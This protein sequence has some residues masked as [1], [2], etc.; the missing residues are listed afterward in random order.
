M[1]HS[2]HQRH[3]T[4][5]KLSRTRKDLK[6]RRVSNKHAASRT[7]SCQV[8]FELHGVAMCT[9][10]VRPH[11]WCPCCLCVLSDPS[12]KGMSS[13]SPSRGGKR[14]L[15]VQDSAD[16]SGLKKRQVLDVNHAK[17]AVV[18][19]Q[20][21]AASTQPQEGTNPDNQTALQT[22]EAVSEDTHSNKAVAGSAPVN[23]VREGDAEES[24]TE[25]VYKLAK[26]LQMALKALSALKGVDSTVFEQ[27]EPAD[28]GNLDLH[29]LCQ[30]PSPTPSQ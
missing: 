28:L 2:T 10:V 26:N 22:T 15:S 24:Q 16:R 20:H 13:S 27:L 7:T 1:K 25:L 30:T 21:A 8:Y 17:G 12:R 11:V 3:S 23:D 18:S 29:T 14:D 9:I 6:R 19:Q 5:S 4:V